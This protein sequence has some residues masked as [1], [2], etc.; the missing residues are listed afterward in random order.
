VGFLNAF[1]TLLILRAEYEETM[2]VVNQE[3]E[4]I[5]E[6][7]LEFLLPHARFLTAAASIGVRA[8]ARAVPVLD[9]LEKWATA[10][11][12]AHIL[13]NTRALRA[14]LLLAQGAV[15]E[16]IKTTGPLESRMPAHGTLGEYLGCGAVARACGGDVEA[17]L[18]LAQQ[19]CDVTVQ[20][21]AQLLARAARAIVKLRDGEGGRDASSQT[22]SFARA[23]GNL[24]DFVAVCRAYPPVLHAVVDSDHR[25]FIRELLRH[26]RD[27]DLARA[28]GLPLERPMQSAGQLSRREQDVAQ[29]LA[30]GMTNRQIAHA[31]FISEVTV[32][33]HVRRILTKLGARSRTEAAVIAMRSTG[34]QPTAAASDGLTTSS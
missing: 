23:T 21:E 7:G 26:T 20:T 33:V 28:V 13:V 9:E 2:A 29:L 4:L 17:A 6:Y 14:R 27:Y 34:D 32:K 16:A 5:N 22:L 11:D 19:A 12:D 1:A 24:T 30:T 31:L 3:A 10:R 8:F 15:D 18:D 25:E